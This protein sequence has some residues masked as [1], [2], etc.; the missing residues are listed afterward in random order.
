MNFED[1]DVSGLLT[2][3]AVPMAINL[4]GAILVLVIGVIVARLVR[5]GLSRAFARS[6]MDVSLSRFLCSVAYVLLLAVVF[7]A[8]LDQLGVPTT[9]AVAILGAAG[10][11]VGLALQGSLGNFASGVLL[12]IFRPYRVG[13]IVNIAGVIGR[14]EEIQVFNTMIHTGDNRV[15]FIP[16]GAITSGTIENINAMP[17]RRIDLVAGIGYADD[18]ALAEE[19]LMEIMAQD[20]RILKEPA[21]GIAVANLGD[22]SVDLNVRPWVNTADYW[23][24]RADLLHRIKTTFDARGISIPFPQRD[25]HL[26]QDKTPSRSVA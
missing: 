19:T 8:A 24:V 5:G 6:R 22:S 21:P 12:L 9:S 10:L 1:V 26:F 18:I 15:L 13:D 20:D 14:V 23:A 7:I 17:T 4:V 25:V 11:A 2:L 16:N 3:Y